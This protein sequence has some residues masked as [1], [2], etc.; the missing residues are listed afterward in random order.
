M[1]THKILTYSLRRGVSYYTNVANILKDF[2]EALSKIF[3]QISTLQRSM[4]LKHLI[5]T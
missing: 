2:L 3:F 4:R 1:V 5:L